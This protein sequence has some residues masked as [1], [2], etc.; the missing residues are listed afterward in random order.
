MIFLI[1]IWFFC[2]LAFFKICQKIGELECPVCSKY[3]FTIDNRR[4]CTNYPK[5][6][7]KANWSGMICLWCFEEREQMWR[8]MWDEYHSAIGYY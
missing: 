5:E 1:V 8:D 6:M 3:T 4:Y 2:F 7:D